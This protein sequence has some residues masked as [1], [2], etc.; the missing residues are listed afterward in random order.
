MA[1]PLSADTRLLF[2]GDSI[3]DLHGAHHAK[4][5]FARDKLKDYLDQ[6]KLSYYPFENFTDIQNTLM[7]FKGQ[8]C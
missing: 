8:P 5:V 7:N 6:D 4:T 1:I 3:T 2:I